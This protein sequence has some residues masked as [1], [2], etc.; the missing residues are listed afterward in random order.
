MSRKQMGKKP[1]ARFS[2]LTVNLN[3]IESFPED[4]LVAPALEMVSEAGVPQQYESRAATVVMILGPA[5]DDL[6][7][8]DLVYCGGGIPRIT[9]FHVDECGFMGIFF[10][11]FWPQHDGGGTAYFI[12]EHSGISFLDDD[13][14]TDRI[15]VDIADWSSL[16]FDSGLA[17]IKTK[18]F[19]A[20]ISGLVLEIL[21]IAVPPDDD[22]TILTDGSE[23][24]FNREKMGEVFG[25]SL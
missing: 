13:D 22:S 12:G 17:K 10:C 21:V 18:P 24:W 6:G 20:L 1:G 25:S 16:P 5:V 19:C 9:N 23:I 11:A 14:E 7:D 2:Q 4:M 15:I 3:M 8:H